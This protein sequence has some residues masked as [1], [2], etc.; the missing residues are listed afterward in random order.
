MA[1]A[2]SDMGRLENEGER[3][4]GGPTLQITE[5]QGCAGR[6]SRPP[7]RRDGKRR[8]GRHLDWGRR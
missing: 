6:P 2:P 5:E 1:E 7:V 3:A 4:G 8:P